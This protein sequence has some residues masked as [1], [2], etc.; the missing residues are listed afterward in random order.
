MPTGG[1][2]VGVG[3]RGRFLRAAGL[4]AAGFFV[5]GAL[6]EGVPAGGLL[7]GSAV[8][9][10]GAAD[11]GFG[12]GFC[13]ADAGLGGDCVPPER[14]RALTAATPGGHSVPAHIHVTV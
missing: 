14:L 8:G 4:F 2:R 10:G 12:R 5:E 7:A 13:L 6:A 1:F 11:A 9:A 3:A